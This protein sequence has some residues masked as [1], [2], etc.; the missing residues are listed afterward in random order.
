M[1]RKELCEGKK[2]GLT[3]IQPCY[4]KKKKLKNHLIPTRT[5]LTKLLKGGKKIKPVQHPI[6]MVVPV[7]RGQPVY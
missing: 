5:S 4:L 3:D 2:R 7:L 6:Q 1:K